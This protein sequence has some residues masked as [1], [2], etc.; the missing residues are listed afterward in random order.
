MIHKDSINNHMVI[1]FNMFFW[2]LLYD[3]L[4]EQKLEG[5]NILA[6]KIYQKHQNI[7]DLKE[8]TYR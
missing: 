5:L 2:A 4:K 1:D 6:H 3:T 8:Q 7:W